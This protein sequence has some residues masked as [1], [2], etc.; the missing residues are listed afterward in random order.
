MKK[1]KEGDWIYIPKLD[2][3]GRAAQVI[4]GRVVSAYID[5]G[6]GA[7][8]TNVID[9]VIEGLSLLERI[10]LIIKIIFRKV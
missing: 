8:I 6:N 9:M 3:Y 7:R 5:Q 4:D 10:L 2:R 1:I